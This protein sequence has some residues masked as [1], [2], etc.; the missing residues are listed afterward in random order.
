MAHKKAADPGPGN[1]TSHN[2]TYE[3]H[4][5][6]EGSKG[7]RRRPLCCFFLFLCFFLCVFLFVFP[8]FF[9]FLKKKLSGALFHLF[10]WAPI[11]L[12]ILL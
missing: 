2:E 11:L 8:F 3:L 10:F 9:L 12:R 6:P 7:Q 5:A 4:T 1:S